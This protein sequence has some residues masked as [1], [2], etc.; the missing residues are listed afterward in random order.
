MR[1]GMYYGDA[2][3]QIAEWVCV[4][5][6]Y[7]YV[8]ME[9]QNKAYRAALKAAHDIAFQQN[10]PSYDRMMS[11]WHVINNVLKEIRE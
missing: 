2:S 10:T 6:K 4:M 1:R 3:N 5:T 7:E 8:R 9:T 11:M